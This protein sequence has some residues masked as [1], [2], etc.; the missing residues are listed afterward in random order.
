[1]PYLIVFPANLFNML[2]W[3]SVVLHL[4][5]V[6]VSLELGLSLRYGYLR[7]QKPTFKLLFQ[8]SWPCEH[9][10]SPSYC[11]LFDYPY[12]Y[13]F[14][15][16][17]DKVCAFLSEIGQFNTFLICIFMLVF[18]IIPD[19]ETIVKIY[20]CCLELQIQEIQH[21]VPQENFITVWKIAKKCHN[22]VKINLKDPIKKVPFFS[23]NSW[24]SPKTTLAA[25]RVNKV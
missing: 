24:A 1:M 23:K 16:I 12:S 2:L 15:T 22:S 20:I 3:K 18:K 4:H 25:N 7:T 6:E 13:T 19:D 21:L 5:S 9:L 10:F 14:T 17:Q 8:K 11:Q